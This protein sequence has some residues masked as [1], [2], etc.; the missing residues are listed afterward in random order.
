MLIGCFGGDILGQVVLKRIH[1]S[2]NSQKTFFVRRILV[3][4]W[5]TVILLEYFTYKSSV[6]SNTRINLFKQS[7]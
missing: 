2:N 3:G 5:G 7:W 6:D 4:Y 1:K